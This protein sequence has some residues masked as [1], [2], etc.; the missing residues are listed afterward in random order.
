[1]SLET[2]KMMS[3]VQ[4]IF[5]NWKNFHQLVWLVEQKTLNLKTLDF[6]KFLLLCIEHLTIV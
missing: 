4:P 6:W 5:A 1:M 3:K 2:V